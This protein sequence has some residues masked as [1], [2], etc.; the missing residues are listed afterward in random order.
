M[1][2]QGKRGQTL[3]KMPLADNAR[4]AIETASPG[5]LGSQHTFGVS[6]QQSVGRDCQQTYIDT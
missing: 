4:G 5:Y 3:K 6:T 2:S 1:D